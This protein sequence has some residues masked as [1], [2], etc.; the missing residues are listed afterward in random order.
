MESW[1]E[2]LLDSQRM[3]EV[4][5]WAIEERGIPSLE[6]MEAAGTAV[7]AATRTAAAGG[8]IR[9]VCG[10]GNN[11]GDGLVTARLLADHDVEALLLFPPDELSADAKANLERCPTARQVP[12][13]ELPDALAG[14]GAVVDALLGTGFSGEPREPVAGAIEAIN[15]AGA[16]VVAVDVASG[17]DAST[18]AAEGAAVSADVTVTF[19]RAKPGHHISPGK[20]LSGN[21]IASEIGIPGGAPVE[22]DAGLIAPSVLALAPRRGPE[23]TKFTSGQVVVVG[24]SR[25]LTGAVCLAAEAAIRAGAGYATACVPASLEPIFEEK[26]TEVMTRGCRDDDGDLVPAA[27]REVIEATDRANAVLLG[28]GL[29]KSDGVF[30]LARELAPPIDAPLVID[31][32]G[33]NAH[34]GRLSGL[35][36]RS[37]PT[38][39]TPHAGELAR[40]LG[41]ESDEVSAARLESACEAADTAQAIVVLKG[42]DT[43][44]VRPDSGP[45]P[46][47]AINA[48]SSPALATAGTGDVLAGAIAALLAR[49]M[50]PFAAACA[51]VFVHARAGRIAARRVGAE[52]VIAGDVLEAVPQALRQEGS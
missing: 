25:G 6:L 22:P 5:R 17:V 42:D 38:I 36:G 3:R 12:V 29:G 34:A 43:L 47:L 18:G 31:A 8:P 35:A 9:I 50:D 45:G 37:A 1:L 20:G 16:P 33:L 2:P 4:D 27:A 15:T 26:L 13:K 11:A 48:L 7:A 30:D 19:H 46:H 51:S 21:V 40:L 24:G 28:P 39:L 14:S 44:V 52:S 10:K 41:R 49:G 23:S 32:D